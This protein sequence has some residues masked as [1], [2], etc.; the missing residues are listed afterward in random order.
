LNPHSKKELDPKSSASANSAI[1]AQLVDK[2]VIPYYY[3]LKILIVKLTTFS[4]KVLKQNINIILK[5][6]QL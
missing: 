4:D 5:T 3:I 2:F 1:L 6:G